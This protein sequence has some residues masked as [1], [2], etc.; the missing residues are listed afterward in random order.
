[1]SEEKPT[2][3]LLEGIATA[4]SIHRYRF[5][6]IPEEDL[7]KILWSGTRAP[8]GT[9]RQPFRFL[10]LRDSE[11]ARRAKALLGEGF[12]K[13]W[14]HKEGAEGWR[15][16]GDGSRSSRRI[17]SMEAVQHFVDNFE[18]I[19]VVVLACF[20]RYREPF[21]GEGASVFPACQNVL[22]A[23]RALGYGAC[24]SGWHRVVEKEL[25]ELLAIPDEVVLSLTITLGRPQGR[26]GPVRRFPVRELVYEDRWGHSAEF[27]SDPPGQPVS[28]SRMSAAASYH[29]ER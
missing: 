1:M 22:L 13:G 8:S 24:F 5:D 14:G 6:P 21:H 20:I 27:V 4:R 16:Q 26:H 3:D 18:K 28:R 25:R 9:N 15:K 17:R 19:P 12:R 11:T 7:A 29:V 2:I 23:A 10:V